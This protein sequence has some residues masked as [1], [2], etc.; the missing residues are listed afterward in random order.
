MS[1]IEDLKRH[2][3]F[4]AKPYMDT[5]GGGLT[6]ETWKKIDG[7]ELYEVS[8]KGRV[9]SLPRKINR[10]NPRWGTSRQTIVW[11]GKLLSGTTKI[12]KNGKPSCVL[13][14][15]RKEGKTFV[16]RVHRLVLAAFVG[17]CPHGLEG[18]HNDGNPLNNEVENL[19]WDTRKAN[20][21]D[22]ILHKTKSAPPILFGEKHWNSKL[23]EKSVIEIRNI[24][25]YRGLFSRIAEQYRISTNHSSRIWKGEGWSHI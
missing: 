16:E 17:A 14:S 15:L 11:K 8:T 1:L 24:K 6:M 22:S 12:E 20:I 10:K 9:R 21:L 3:G 25:Y 13:V 7:F 23:S 18:C 2:E 5:T 19:R 4:R